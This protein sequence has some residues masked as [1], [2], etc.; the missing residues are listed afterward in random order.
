VRGDVG[1]PNGQNSGIFEGQIDCSVQYIGYYNVVIRALYDM[2]EYDEEGN[3]VYGTVVQYDP[4][5]VSCPK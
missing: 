1:W 3:K 5:G 4:E 2:G